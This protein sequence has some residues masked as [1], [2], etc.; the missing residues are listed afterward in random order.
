MEFFKGAISNCKKEVLTHT[1]GE[2]VVKETKIESKRN[3]WPFW[4]V[5]VEG[6]GRWW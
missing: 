3:L 6:G 1:E 4:D 5:R 2:I